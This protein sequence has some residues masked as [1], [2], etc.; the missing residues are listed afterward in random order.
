MISIFRNYVL[1]KQEE[2]SR[3]INFN[4]FPEAIYSAHYLEGINHA[5]Q[6]IS[7]KKNTCEITCANCYLK[8]IDSY[9]EILKNKKKEKNYLDVAYI[10]GYIFG[11]LSLLELPKNKK[12]KLDY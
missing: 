2:L 9:F 12:W 10:D 5:C 4:D 7:E 1:D 3:R 6:F 11:L 8:M